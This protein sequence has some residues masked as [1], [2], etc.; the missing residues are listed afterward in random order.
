MN[1]GEIP[2]NSSLFVSVCP[3]SGRNSRRCVV[4]PRP[5][6]PITQQGGG[7]APRAPG[8]TSRYQPPAGKKARE[9]QECVGINREDVCMVG[10]AATEISGSP[11]DVN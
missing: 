3:P 2:M 5:R 8:E 7:H 9:T 1:P 11:L 10:A 6:R 4:Q